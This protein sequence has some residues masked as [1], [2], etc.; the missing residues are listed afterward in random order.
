M[1]TFTV[2]VPHYSEKILLSLRE[3][4]REE[5]HNTR[6]TQLEYLKQLHPVEWDNFVKDTKILA[7]EHPEDDEKAITKSDDLTILLHWFQDRITGIHPSHAYLGVASGSNTLPHGLGY[8]E[9]LEGHQTS[10]QGRESGYC[11]KV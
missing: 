4:I 3:I 8:D 9:L 7:E 6:V 10:I 11:S 1:P 2:L 5:D